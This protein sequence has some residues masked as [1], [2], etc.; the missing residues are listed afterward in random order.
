MTDVEELARTIEAARRVEDLDRAEALLHAA[1]QSNG[2]GVHPHLVYQHG[3]NLIARAR[4]DEARDTMLL[5]TVGLPHGA[6]LW[7]H[8]A[9]CSEILGEYEVARTSYREAITA[10]RLHPDQ[11]DEA[12]AYFGLGAVL[13]RQGNPTRALQFWEEGLTKPFQSTIARFERSQ[14]L[15]A[16]GRYEAGWAAYEARHLFPSLP[17]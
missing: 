14:V 10:Y 5:L 2:Q 8:A 11:P 13:F 4:Y 9:R 17:I 16:L 6:L 1:L 12:R 7:L 3:M 15:L